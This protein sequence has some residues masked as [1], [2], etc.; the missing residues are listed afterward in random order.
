MIHDYDE[1]QDFSI[2]K[3]FNFY[4]E[5]N[6]GLSEL[7]QKR[8]LLVTESFMQTEGFARS[9]TPGIYINFT[10]QITKEASGNTIGV[11]LGGGGGGGVNV[12]IGGNIP[13]GSNT[14]LELTMDFVDVTKD[15]LVWQAIVKSKF[16]QNASPNTKTELFHRMIKK[17]LDKYPPEKKN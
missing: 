11:G 8:L 5:M 10:S 13:I 14:Y 9:E 1:K 15:E 12:G 7:D 16:H 3:T 2:Y 17:S 6:S 4:P